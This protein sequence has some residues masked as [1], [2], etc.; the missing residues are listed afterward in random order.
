MTTK[1]S[2][3]VRPLVRHGAEM[4]VA[5][6]IGMALLGPL[7]TPGQVELAALWMAVSMSV[8]MALWMRYRGHGRIFE[9]CAAMVV[10]YLVLLVP[11]WLG[12][13]DGPAVEMGGHLLMVP[14]MIAVLVLHRHEHGTP[15]TNPVIRAL[16]E[17]WPAVIALAVSFDFW[18]APVVPPV[19][20]LLVCQAAYLFWGRRAPRTQLAVFGLYALLAVAVLLVSP[21]NGVL[22]IALGWGAH[23]VWDLVHHVRNAV[24]PRWWS[25]FCGVFDLVI[26]VTI[27]MVWF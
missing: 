1:V 22:L 11:Y 3:A 8:P 21:H 17:R 15:S 18:Q 14:A 9:M 25:E 23:A 6:L 2:P 20:T 7:W 24:V 27:L 13:L 5:M 4:L 10:P 19:W 16:G 26:A 12:V